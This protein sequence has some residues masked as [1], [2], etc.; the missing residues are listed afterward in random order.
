MPILV[1]S[2]ANWCVNVGGNCLVWI[3]FNEHEVNDWIP[4]RIL[5]LVFNSCSSNLDMVHFP[6]ATRYGKFQVQTLKNDELMTINFNDFI[7]TH[8]PFFEVNSVIINHNLNFTCN[9]KFS[10]RLII[11]LFESYIY[12]CWLILLSWKMWSWTALR[13]A[14]VVTEGVKVCGNIISRRKFDPF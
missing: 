2:W 8:F 4:I 9:F 11:L 10:T 7:C 3:S 12:T 1:N 6:W 5:L 14:K 13:L